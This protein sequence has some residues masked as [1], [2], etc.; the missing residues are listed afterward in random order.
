MVRSATAFL[1]L[2]AVIGL[3]FLLE[4][5]KPVVLFH[6]MVPTA[7]MISLSIGSAAFFLFPK[8]V[9]QRAL[10]DLE[11]GQPAS[12]ASVA[13]WRFLERASY[14]V[15][16]LALLLG[17]IITAGFLDMPLQIVGGKVGACL[18]MLA[19]GVLQGMAMA[20]LRARVEAGLP[21]AVPLPIEP[22]PRAPRRVHGKG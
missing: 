12:P 4:G 8:E 16:V 18:T 14:G 22:R 7:V 13:V 20:M 10:R 2:C 21:V 3:A 6:P 5:G 19:Y 1:I 9:R 17:L 11:G 15:G